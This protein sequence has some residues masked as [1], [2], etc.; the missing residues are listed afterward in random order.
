MNPANQFGKLTDSVY[1]NLAARHNPVE[2]AEACRSDA[3]L[4]KLDGQESSLSPTCGSDR[5]WLLARL[6]LQEYDAFT[7]ELVIGRSVSEGS[8]RIQ[9]SC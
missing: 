6:I 3:K 8:G 7:G 9:G 4:F 2:I 5:C 1:G